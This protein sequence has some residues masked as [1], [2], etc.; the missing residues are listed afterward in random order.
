MKKVKNLLLQMK[1]DASFSKTSPP[2]NYIYLDKTL[3]LT[4]E[5]FVSEILKE[6]SLPRNGVCLAVKDQDIGR[7]SILLEEFYVELIDSLPKIAFEE[8]SIIG[9][10]LFRPASPKIFNYFLE[11]ARSFD[12]VWK[13]YDFLPD[14]TFQRIDLFLKLDLRK[15][16]FLFS[17]FEDFEST[18]DTYFLVREIFNPIFNIGKKKFFEL[19]RNFS[20]EDRWL[21]EFLRLKKP[22]GAMSLVAR[23]ALDTSK[24]KL[25]FEQ[26]FSG[27]ENEALSRTEKEFDLG[28]F[29]EKVKY[30]R[31]HNPDLLKNFN[32]SENFLHF[33]LRKIIPK[34]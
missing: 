4:A 9:R 19:V 21:V 14:L 5:N 1:I 30:F 2:R 34:S 10:L 17:N 6:I 29:Y 13:W 31:G 24:E 33:I 11:K 16:D 20:E 32:Y 25:S 15:S 8:P 12:C 7:L 23:E 27:K 3:P 26:I 22:N 18:I 28:D